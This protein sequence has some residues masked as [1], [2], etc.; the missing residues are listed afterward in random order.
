[1]RASPI[2]A[3]ALA[4][5]CCTSALRAQTEGVAEA[6]ADGRYDLALEAAEGLSD[7]VL[8][9]EWRFQVLHAAGD[10]AGALAAAR[11]GLALA[12]SHPRLAPNAANVALTLGEGA[13]AL[14]FCDAW[15]AALD[16]SAI[17]EAGARAA[18]LER[19]AR[20]RANALALRALDE[21]ARSAT[22]S[23]QLVVAVVLGGTVLA[24]LALARRARCVEARA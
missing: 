2:L 13:L 4:L 10:L 5:A 17:A 20:Y 1:M 23:A 12:P 24:L 8:A 9:T 14:E 19:L 21:R 3:S 16:A 18:E 22:K 11:A 6:F 15:Q 7:P